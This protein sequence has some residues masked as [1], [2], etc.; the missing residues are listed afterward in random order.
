MQSPRQ[1]RGKI[2]EDLAISCLENR[3]FVILAR[4]QRIPIQSMGPYKRSWVEIDALAQD[5]RALWLI[6]AK[7][8]CNAASSSHPLLS[9]AQY[10][11]L[12][13]A[14]AALRKIHSKRQVSWLLAWRNRGGGVEFAEN[15]CYF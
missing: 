1:I 12:M 13:R 4:N 9:R 7:D 8:H 2:F 10:V 6:E 11:R 5:S 3:G 14:L 15:P